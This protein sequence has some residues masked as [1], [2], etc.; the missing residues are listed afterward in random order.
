MANG[1]E[2][3]GMITDA[4]ATDLNKDGAMDLIVVGEWMSIKIMINEHGK[5]ID[6]S[7]DWLGEYIGLVECN[8]RRRL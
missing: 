8:H 6:K 4:L 7:R 3:T 2:H 1:L 5:L